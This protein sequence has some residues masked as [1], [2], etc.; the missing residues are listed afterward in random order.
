RL[1]ASQRQAIEP[2]ALLNLVSA[3]RDAVASLFR[4][5]TSNGLRDRL[6]WLLGETSVVASRVW[7]AI[8]NRSMALANCAFVR[9]LGDELDNPTLGAVARMFESN[10]RSDA[11][12]LIGCDGDIVEGLR[13]LV[14]ASAVEH[15]LSPAARAL[16]A[17]EQAQAYAILGMKS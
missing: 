8:G 16:L 13:L 2:D 17:A 4:R 7:G 14:E 5:A 9:K 3:H 1:L 6:G 11:A 15:L 12:T 10:L